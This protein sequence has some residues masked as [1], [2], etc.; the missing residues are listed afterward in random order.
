MSLF[1]RLT[2]PRLTS[3]FLFTLLLLV[4]LVIAAF[5]LGST[6]SGGKGLVINEVLASNRATIADEDGDYADWFE[7]Y[8]PGRKKVSLEGYFVTNDRANPFMWSLPAQEIEPGGFLLLFASGKDRADLANG[9]LHTNFKLGSSGGSLYLIDPEASIVDSVTYPDLLFNVSYGRTGPGKN[10]WAYFLEATP[11]ATNDTKPYDEVTNMPLAAEKN[12]FINEI[13]TDNRTWLSDED[14]DLSDWIELFNPGTNPVDLKGYWLSDKAENPFKWRFPAAVLPSSGYLVVFAS[15]KNKTDPESAYLHT[16]FSLN[17]QNDTLIIST[18]EGA[19]VDTLKIFEVPS[20]VSY[21][22]DEKDPSRWLYYPRPTPGEANYTTGFEELAKN[23]VPAL[24]ISEAVAVNASTLADEDGDYADWVEIY[25]EGSSAVNLEGYGLSDRAQE[26]FRWRFPALELKAKER[27]V[28]FA[29]GKDRRSTD[30]ANLHTNFKIKASGETIVLTH[31]SGVTIDMLPT[32][33]LA[34]DLSAGKFSGGEERFFFTTPNPGKEPAGSY[35]SELSAPVTITPTGGFYDTALTVTI[36]AANPGAEIRYTTDGSEPGET[37]KLY[38][39]P[40]TLTE[41]T[42]LRARAFEKDKLPGPVENRSFFIGTRHNLTVVSLLLNP[43]DL[44]DPAQGI[45]VKG[46]GASSLFPY[47]GANFWKDIEK[48]VH[49]ELFEPGGELGLSLDAGLK[50]GGQFSRGMDQKAFNVFARN[51]YGFKEINYPLF[52]NKELSSFKAIS[53]RASGQDAVYSKIRDIVMT[54]LLENAQVDYQGYRQAVLYLNGEYW[55]IYNIRERINSHFIAG[56][57][58][59]DPDKIDL[60]QANW[61]VKEGSNED[62]LDLLDFVR[63]HD[64]SLEE[65]YAFVKTRLDIESYIDALIVQIYFAQTDQ[66]N[67]RYWREQ[68]P[69]AKWRWIIY[70]L[71]WGMWLNHVHYNTLASMT[72]PAGTGAWKNISTTLTVKLMQNEDFKHEFTERFAWH[73]KNTFTPERVISRIDELAAN[74]E[75]EMPRQ[76]QRWGGSMERWQNELE[77]MREFSRRRP[78]IVKEQL[79]QK[80]NLNEQEMQVFAER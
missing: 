8:N 77:S 17:D 2:N 3:R 70:D 23:P 63:N 37:S 48:P 65:N 50:I 28:I 67:I 16:N 41:T 61:I 66:G 49:L 62:Y 24:I 14:G 20:N 6:F 47:Y 55:G 18:P 34:A 40:L 11:G 68:K 43:D 54:S 72:N 30:G 32:G 76:I 1:N 52:F 80:F 78:A 74:I 73:L 5:S 46:Y 64:L 42:V 44:W 25:N 36:E 45:Y 29:S 51:K 75:E 9:E 22:R 12:I 38:S 79:R 4:A 59:L 56:N 10:N 35:F 71:D 69:G 7:I 58:G 60:L 21:G 26:P 27:L 33:K 13:I 53:L 57:H 15:G 39:T 31:P 19:T